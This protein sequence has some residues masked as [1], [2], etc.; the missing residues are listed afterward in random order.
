MPVLRTSRQRKEPL[1]VQPDTAP[2]LRNVDR[3][4]RF[5]IVGQ[6]HPGLLAHHLPA[7]GTRVVNRLYTVRI[8]RRIAPG[9][10]SG[11]VGQVI[12]ILIKPEVG[13][14]PAQV[15]CILRH[16]TR[17]ERGVDVDS[18]RR[19]RIADNLMMCLS[20]PCFESPSVQRGNWR[21]GRSEPQSGHV[22]GIA[23]HIIRQTR[24]R[25]FPAPLVTVARGPGQVDGL[26]LLVRLDVGLR[27]ID[28]GAQIAAHEG[29][30]AL[31][32]AIL[33]CIGVIAL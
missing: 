24:E 21:I 13:V 19:L 32:D 33:R 27:P 14:G 31:Y 25:I 23:A 18:D 10:Q 1:A 17:S 8:L 20:A 6:R 11:L 3:S 30:A 5:F 15:E 9:G 12:F 4:V 28:H 26:L 16:I 2:G 22:I 29:I 7:P